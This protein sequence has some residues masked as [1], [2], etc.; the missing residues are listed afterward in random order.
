MPTTTTIKNRLLGQVRRRLEQFGLPEE[1]TA[2]VAAVS[3][4]PDSVALAHLLVTL[5]ESLGLTLFVAHLNHG[6][7]GEE[8]YADEVFVES[9][10]RQLDVPFDAARIDLKKL[11]EAAGGNL[12]SLAR[13]HRYSFLQ[14]V[15]ERRNAAWIALGHT[16]DDQ[17]ETILLALIRGTG[18]KGL[19]G[20]PAS[21]RLG[22]QTLI[23][24]LIDVERKEIIEFLQAEGL[25]YREDA[26]NQALHYR[27]N[28]LRYKVLPELRRMNP[29]LN[30]VVGRMGQ[31][32]A[33]EERFLDDVARET[34]RRI[35][36]PAPQDVDLPGREV[37]WFTHFGSVIEL[38]P[39]LLR[40]VAKLLLHDH[41]DKSKVPVAQQVESMLDAIV[42]I[43]PQWELSLSDQV[44]LLRRYEGILLARKRE[45][46]NRQR[47]HRAGARPQR[48]GETIPLPDE[49]ELPV[50]ALGEVLRIQRLPKP[51]HWRELLNAEE[52]VQGRR[53]YLNA[54]KIKGNLTLRCRRPG[55][56]LSVFGLGG[57]RKVKEL[58]IEA[59]VPLEQRQQPRLLTCGDDVLWLLGCTINDHYKIDED[60]QQLLS[61]QRVRNQ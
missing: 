57:T 61:V 54:D 18:R 35:T 60:T 43:E 55:D 14:K 4:G 52:V 31:R 48:T 10:A 40:R 44:S 20:M 22:G 9:L 2:I 30:R 21:R 38:P 5:R 17:A 25:P 37:L 11:H 51:Q 1:G 19:S 13:R 36:E 39:A 34:L 28:R 23:R 32:F 15:A 24:P 27:R 58:M 59:K 56:R 49:G 12:Q 3:G 42:A 46:P 50:A 7:R 8:A 47:S 26:S 53:A 6:L 45:G 41:V 29:R 16:L 33:D